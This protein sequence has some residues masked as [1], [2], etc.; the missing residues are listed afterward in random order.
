VTLVHITTVDL[1]LR[2]LLRG[3]LRAFREHGFRVVGISAPGPWVAELE[4]EGLV[5]VAVPALRRRWAPAA[6]VRALTDLFLAL[7][8]LRPDIVHTH[9]PKAGVLG[10]LAARL[11]GVPVVVNTVHGFY[12]GEGALRRGLGLWAERLA[13]RC[14][15]FEFCQSREDL[16][17]LTRMGVIRPE[18]SAY[19]G[20]GVDLRTF[21]P[22]AVHRASVRERLGI[23]HDA[24]VIG[25]VGRLV[26]E[27]GY[28][29][30]FAMAQRLADKK[31][32]PVVLAVGPVETAKADAVPASLVE[33]LGRR[34]V[35]R[36]LG[37]RTDMPGLYAAMDVFVLASHREGFPRSAIEAAAMG[38]PLV[39]TDIRGCREVVRDGVNGFL[40]PPGD[41][42]AL[43]ACVEQLAGD[44]S[45]RAR[46]GQESRR[47]AVAE[48]DEQRVIETTLAVYGRLLRERSG[49]RVGSHQT[50]RAT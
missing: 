21:D 2:F 11:A 27:K 31:P 24:V 14:S 36:F 38:L 32:A 45:L 18:R 34:G 5:H 47:R 6:D 39:L 1:S 8:R 22:N 37:M 7:R 46:F 13:A 35:V 33:D 12:T 43:A 4:Q 20:N 28:R 17:T 15:D 3:Q 29:E 50:R 16:E 44:P 9:T 48:F 10:R 25:T 30:F 40:V 19:L 41:S 23:A 42:A 26:W 49:A